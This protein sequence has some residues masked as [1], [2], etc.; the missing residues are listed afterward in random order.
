VACHLLT[1]TFEDFQAELLGYENLLDF[2]HSSCNT[3]HHHFAF[4]AHKSKA[5]IYGRKKG[6]PL[7]STKLQSAVSSISRRHKQTRS[8]TPQLSSNRPVCEICGKI[9]NIAIDCFH[10]FDYLHQGRFPPQ[11]LAA[12]V[13]ED[14]AT[15][16]YQVWYM[17]S[18]ANA[19]ITSSATNLTDQNS[20]HD[21]GTVTVGNG[22]GLQ[23]LNTGSTTF[24]LGKSNFHLNNI[25]H[26]PQVATNLISI[27]RFCLDNNCYFILTDLEKENLTGKI[28]L[29]GVVD[30]GLYPLAGCQNSL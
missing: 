8:P 4:A 17:D 25:L 18:G 29:R 10:R 23:I 22:S 28:L 1:L 13:A 11:D 6:P 30:N 2:N 24:N 16:D 19:H 21:S 27:N 15:L 26:C 9:G 7:H 3:D 14:N 20:C 5:P 12:M